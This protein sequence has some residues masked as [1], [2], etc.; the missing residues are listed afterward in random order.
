MAEISVPRLSDK[1]LLKI[2]ID[3]TL[4]RHSE[5]GLTDKATVAFGI[6]ANSFTVD[7]NGG[8][9]QPLLNKLL[10]DDSF[11]TKIHVINIRDVG[12][13]QH[14]VVSYKRS[15]ISFIDTFVTPTQEVP[16][17]AL[18]IGFYLNKLILANAEAYMSPNAE[19]R[20]DIAS[21]HHDVL[22]RLEGF[23]A[24][25]IEKQVQQVQKL[26]NDKQRFLDERGAEFAEKV[27]AQD[28]AYTKKL[29]DLEAKYQKR[30]EELDER[31]QK[32]DDA[33]NTTARR[34]TTTR[35][36]E[37]AQERA[38]KFSFSSNVESRTFAALILGVLLAVLGGG[39]AFSAS[40]QLESKQNQYS[41]YLA[42]KANKEE[43]S[44]MN[45]VADDMAKQHIYFLYLRILLGSALTI[46]SIIYLIRWFNSWANRIA[47][48]ELDNQMF[49]RDLNRAQLAVEMSLEWNEKKDGEIPP[50]LLSSLTEGLFQPQN[51]PQQ[52][53]LHPAE[54]IAAAILRTSDKVTLPLGGS[55]IETSGKKINKA[56]PFNVD[57]D[58]ARS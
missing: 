7:I 5:L 26:E 25:L 12:L 27:N 56:K 57:G 37:E 50:R 18:S 55:V 38:R 9:L 54:Q 4:M 46:S 48:Q 28:E 19:Q 39:I 42:S 23:S 30:S 41:S 49:I 31:Q 22:T 16:V 17:Q 35:T 43:P 44:E 36:L 45:L 24:E 40:T 33:D 32:I 15:A 14:F 11:G 1:A 13:S 34:K 29:E 52:E 53:L 6:G 2:F 3:E 21:A 20:Y 51:S 8:G 10:E 47:Q 58:N